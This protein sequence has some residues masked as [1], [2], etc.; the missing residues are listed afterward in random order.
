M[1]RFM[2]EHRSLGEAPVA[3]EKHGSR[4]GC[5]SFHMLLGKSK[6]FQRLANYFS[7]YFMSFF[8][9]L[10]FNKKPYMGREAFSFLLVVGRL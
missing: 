2:L 1:L 9:F 3:P 8:S 5:Q 6:V 4:C 7:R 10:V